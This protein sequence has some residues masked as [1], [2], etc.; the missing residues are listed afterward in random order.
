[1][2]EV[3]NPIEDRG[4][5]PFKSLEIFGRKYGWLVGLVALLAS[6]LGWLHDLWAKFGDTP[7][8]PFVAAMPF[9]VQL[10]MIVLLVV[11]IRRPRMDTAHPR[12]SVRTLKLNHLWQS[13]WVVMILIYLVLAAI[14]VADAKLFELVRASSARRLLEF[15]GKFISNGLMQ[16]NALILLKMY[17]EL[18]E[19]RESD[20]LTWAG[21]VAVLA[22]LMSLHLVFPHFTRETGMAL[23]MVTGLTGLFS[24]LAYVLFLTSISVMTPGSLVLRCLYLYAAIQVFWVVFN[25]VDLLRASVL[26]VVLALKLVLFFHVSY[27]FHSGR[28]LKHF[29]AIEGEGSKQ[30]VLELDSEG[31]SGA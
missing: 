1:M 25:E 8:G 29:V 12:A 28:V 17:S 16:A 3:T 2:H 27:L 18:R 14:P 20:S 19:K 9:F 24:A 10:W 30:L 31:K 11:M 21:W 13:Y 6:T 23:W 22:A 15:Y 26:M 5:S 4:E 7:P